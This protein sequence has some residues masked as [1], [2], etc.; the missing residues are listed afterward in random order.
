MQDIVHRSGRYN[1]L[2]ASIYRLRLDIGAAT[3]V[4]NVHT[5]VG[6]HL[7]LSSMSLSTAR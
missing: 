5:E 2:G 6:V 4:R 1:V 7:L 3:A